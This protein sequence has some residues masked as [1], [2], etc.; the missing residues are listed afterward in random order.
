MKK[1]CY[2]F[3]IDLLIWCLATPLAYLLRGKGA[4]MNHLDTVLVVSA[5]AIPVKLA[6]IYYEK[7]YV[8]SWHRVGV[9]DLF[10]IGRGVLIYTVAFMVITV[11]LR[12]NVSV[13]YS[14]P[15]I[16]A[17]L[18]F[19]G[20]GGVRII[21]RLWHEYNFRFYQV[22]AEKSKR[23]LI[24][25]A[26]EAGSMIARQMLR[27]PGKGMDPIGFLDDNPDKKK[28]R[29]LGLDVLGN[30]DQALAVIRKYNIDTLLIAMPSVSGEVVRKLVK[31]VNEKE[32]LEYKIVPSMTALISG[33]ISINE[34]RD[35]NLEDLLRR[36]PVKLNT[37]DIASYL[38]E[39][40]VLVTGAGGS[41][42]S[43][44]VRQIISFNPKKILLVDKSEYNIY[45]IEQELEKEHRGL[46]YEPIIAN[47]RDSVTLANIFN[48]FNPEIVFH[49]AAHKHVPIMEKNPVQAI[50][51]NVG[52]TKNLTNLCLEYG[53][54][55][56]VNIS[57][58]KAVNPTSVMG[59]TK[60]IA[61]YIV[62]GGS[63][64]A[65]Y[66]QIFVSVRFGNVLGSRGSVVPKFRDQIKQREAITV[67]HPDMTR[68]FMT[69]PE[70]SQL[71]LQ[72]GGLNQSGAVYV[73]DMGEPVKILDLAKDLI[74][75]SGLEPDIDIPIKIVGIRPGEKLYEEL[76]TAEEGTEVTRY[77]KI[78]SA[79]QNGMPQHFDQT[80]NELMNAAIDNNE[81]AIRSMLMDLIPK[82]ELKVEEKE[83]SRSFI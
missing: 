3:G 71:V 10:T 40:I 12:G 41:I 67:T 28:Q 75:L 64:R 27:H 62:E 44:V 35:V 63:K 21:S 61:E 77:T 46:N 19:L 76:M 7:F 14:I 69:I 54:R 68:Y 23:V 6:I 43:E 48:K 49:A 17:M 50:L 5:C 29:L 60:R 79:R 20:L 53:V 45:K 56:F 83:S 37:A 51:N 57:T 16:G 47:V 82:N 2:K 52:G 13:P 72:A 8:Q 58:D 55:H 9:R 74:R 30:I 80:L 38:N 11:S 65:N 31:E 15:L 24:A 36:E 32:G 34:I 22:S 70:A 78:N 81:T 4:W 39:R 33:E 73:L 25:G 1:I 59:A 66:D 42:G 18:A 26:G